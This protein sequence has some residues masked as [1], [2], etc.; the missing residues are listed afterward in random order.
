MFEIS[1]SYCYWRFE[2][3]NMFLILIS[4]ETNFYFILLNIHRL[5]LIIFKNLETNSAHRSLKMVRCEAFLKLLLVLFVM[6]HLK[7]IQA[8]PITEDDLIISNIEMSMRNNE[9]S[10][11]MSKS[12]SEEKNVY[13]QHRQHYLNNDILEKY[14]SLSKS[15]ED[16]NQRTTDENMFLED[17]KENKDLLESILESAEKNNQHKPSNPNRNL[18]KKQKQV[19]KD[20]KRIEKKSWKIPMKTLALYT[21]NSHQGQNMMDELTEAFNAF[22]DHNH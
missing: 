14:L 10:H 15:L 20:K 7:M 16:D 6:L 13:S 12:T 11:P 9:D 22:K 21:E 1:A 4:L 19:R 17:L 2:T 8:A 3:K 5:Y 18:P